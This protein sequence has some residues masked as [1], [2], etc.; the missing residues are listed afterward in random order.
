MKSEI[1]KDQNLTLSPATEGDSKDIWEWRNDEQTRLMSITTEPVSWESH[2]AWFERSLQNPNRLLFVASNEENK[3]NGMCRFDIDTEK[4]KAEV[5]INLNPQ[6]RGKNLSQKLLAAS[7]ESFAKRHKIPLT[8]TIKKTNEASIKCFTR[9]GF[10]LEK[11]DGDYNYYTRVL[12]PPR[13][14]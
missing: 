8:A 6:F 12:E 5:S 10:V 3:K 9:C 14:V 4:E 1:E 7:V 2:Q 11:Q 13:E